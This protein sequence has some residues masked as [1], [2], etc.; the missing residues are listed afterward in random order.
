ML[1]KLKQSGT[2]FKIVTAPLWQSVEFRASALKNSLEF[3]IGEMSLK[4]KERKKCKIIPIIHLKLS[5]VIYCSKV[6][7]LIKAKDKIKN[8]LCYLMSKF[9]QCFGITQK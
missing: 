9:G 1:Y 6:S 3:R 8:L 4:K 5:H 7:V 2:S